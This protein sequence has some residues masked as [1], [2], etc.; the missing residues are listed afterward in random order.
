MWSSMRIR[1]RDWGG[2][3][4]PEHPVYVCYT[5]TWCPRG[6]ENA[7]LFCL[8]FLCCP[9]PWCF[10]NF[11]CK[12]SSSMEWHGQFI[13]FDEH[14]FFLQASLME[15][16]QLSQNSWGEE[17]SRGDPRRKLRQQKRRRQCMLQSFGVSNKWFK[18]RSEALIQTNFSQ[19]HKSTNK[20][21]WPGYL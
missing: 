2:M 13:G 10:I 20:S 17:G 9:G 1:D 8:F 4:N 11:D 18:E 6:R 15:K 19:I 16:Q 7:V 14:I 3:G 21:I 12:F 5:C